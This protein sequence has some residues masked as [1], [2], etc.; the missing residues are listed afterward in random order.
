MMATLVMLL[1]AGTVLLALSYAADGPG[2]RRP[3]TRLGHGLREFG[4]VSSV[5]GDS[6]QLGRGLLAR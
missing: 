6:V 4:R 1:L 3:L 2:R 5:Y